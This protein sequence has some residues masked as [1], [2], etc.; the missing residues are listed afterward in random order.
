MLSK[1]RIGWLALALVAALFCSRDAHGRSED[2]T[3]REST[4]VLAQFLALRVKEIPEALL[5]EAHAVVIIPDLIK[6]GFVLGGQR[7]TGIV[8]IKDPKTGGWSAPSFVS[9]TGG[10]IGWQIG[11]Q[12]S[13][14]VLVFKTQRSVEGL[15]EGKFTLGADAAVAAGPVGRQA[16]AATDAQ[17]KAEIYSYARA[18]GLFAGVAIDGS[19][20]AIEHASNAAYYGGTGIAGV[21][22]PVPEGALKLVE[23]IA[24]ATA[25]ADAGGQVPQA[26][27]PSQDPSLAPNG[28]IETTPAPA[29]Q[30]PSNPIPFNPIPQGATP[31][32]AIP[33]T[34]NSPRALF[35]PPRDLGAQAPDADAVRADVARSA[36]ELGPL[37]DATWQR[38]L[39]LPA[40]VYERGRHPSAT[41]VRGSLERFDAVAADP[42]YG[43]LNSRPEFRATRDTLKA[44]L[45]TLSA[46]S[47]GPRLALPPPPGVPR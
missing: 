8:V 27:F 19:V 18:R 17:L 35:A 40:E 34:P 16:K 24:Q 5:S 14:I 29:S 37:L 7:G 22:Q 15:L 2:A 36:T 6:V 10:S 21:A 33:A 44:Y 25:N 46:P 45:D 41:V 42:R 4:D 3:I 39:A 30:I 20:L 43:Q 28:L 47:G 9:L 32:N 11:A 12:S 38:Y 23:Y 1:H 31:Q 26:G 13:D